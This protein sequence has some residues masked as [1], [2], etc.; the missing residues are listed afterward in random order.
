MRDKFDNLLARSG[1]KSAHGVVL[2]CKLHMR[3]LVS[4]PLSNLFDPFD[5]MVEDNRFSILYY[6][7]ELTLLQSEPLDEMT[8]TRLVNIH[9]RQ[10]VT[11]KASGAQPMKFFAVGLASSGMLFAFDGFLAGH[12]IEGCDNRYVYI[13]GQ[14][15][16][17]DAAWDI[18]LRLLLGRLYTEL[19]EKG[20]ARSGSNTF[21]DMDFM[22]NAG[23]SGIQT[24]TDRDSTISFLG[25]TLDIYS[26]R[27]LERRLR[28]QLKALAERA[29]AMKYHNLTLNFGC[30]FL[31]V[32]LSPAHGPNHPTTHRFRPVVRVSSVFKRRESDLNT[33]DEGPGKW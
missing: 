33:F 14:R 1:A 31:G 15:V 24:K 3:R 22:S 29:R 7:Y 5:H 26:L 18:D 30:E 32:R 4:G 11:I 20:Y 21:R 28:I 8:L 19:I 27:Q 12:I 6:I 9:N 2:E 13:R 23:Y 25:R 17:T 10:Q 16:A